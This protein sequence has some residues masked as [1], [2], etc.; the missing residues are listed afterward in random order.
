MKPVACLIIGT[1]CLLSATA[2][3]HAHLEKSTP[4]EGSVIAGAPVALVLTFS[5]P[6]RLTALSVQKDSDAT[7]PVPALETTVA[8][9]HN[10][11]IPA[12]APGAYT[13]RWRVVSDDTHVMAGE[14]HFTVK[15]SASIAP[16]E[17]H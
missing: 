13:V 4:A 1:S 7:Q 15:A 11:A 17:K 10:V 12:M 14:L 9:T 5:E 3:A 16:G 2:T 6:A 8:L